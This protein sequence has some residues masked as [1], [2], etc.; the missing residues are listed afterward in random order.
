M[1][2][3]NKCFQDSEI[4]SII[5]KGG[6]RGKCPTCRANNVF[7]YDTDKEHELEPLFEQL[8]NVY[9]PQNDF[10][11]GFPIDE[12]KSIADVLKDDWNIFS[13][14]SNDTVLQMLKSLAPSLV[15]EFPSLF[16]EPVGIPEKY[17]K[18]YLK[19]H[20]ILHS[21][22]WSDFVEAIKHKN[23]FHTNMVDLQRLQEYCMQIAERIVP[24]KKRYYRGR[25]AH[26]KKGFARKNMGAPP[27][28]MATAG[29]VNSEGISRLYLT[30]NFDTTFHEI[31]AAEYDY[32]SVGAF[33]LLE[34]ILVVD[35]SRIDKI[36][37]FGDEVDTTVLAINREHLLK[38]NQEMGHPMR[39]GDSAIDYL[40]TQYI[41]DFI[42]SICDELGNPLFDGIRYQ[43]AMHSA[44]SNLTIFYPEKFKCTSS[45]T[46]EVTNLR[47][48]HK[49]L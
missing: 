30:D 47:F 18:D 6:R 40:P 41:G 25:I 21:A 10:P 43:S 7:L 14:I 48:D 32:V 39:R 3:C 11:P 27:K 49:R 34:P 23:R 13:D 45:R 12:A 20:S 19:E 42:M 4:K 29:R 15:C 28:E 37:P 1:I 8:I 35:L 9:T 31:R 38:I 17:D 22:H 2:I 44:G 16:I 24:S 46:Y 33:M 5:S 26:D 36:S